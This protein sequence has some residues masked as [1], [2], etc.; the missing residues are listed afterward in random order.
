[1]LEFITSAPFVL[2]FGII[3][4]ITI[5]VLLEFEENGWATTIFSVG[6]TLTGWVYKSDIWDFVSS[7]PMPTIYFALTYIGAGLVWSLIKWRV[8]IKSKSDRFNQIK[9]EFINKHGDIKNNWDDW[10]KYLNNKISGT[11]AYNGDAPETVVSKVIPQA[12][13]KKTLIVSWIS[14]WPMS[15][16]ATLLNN[17]FRRFFEWIYSIFSGLY[18]KISKSAAADMMIGLE[19][20][21]KKADKKI[22]K[23]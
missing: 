17:P 21:E 20:E 9:K 14:Y 13:D 11:Y 15:L 22:L 16:S 4:A 2:V 8:Y 12:I 7:N 23:D 3:A 5:A 1:M 6:M 10:I 18:D 19:K